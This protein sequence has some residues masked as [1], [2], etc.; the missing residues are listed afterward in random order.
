M[1]SILLAAGYATRLYPLTKDQ[2]KPLLKVADKAIADYIV[3][4]LMALEDM[5]CC[6]VVT[7]DKFYPHFEEWRSNHPFKERLEIVNDGTKNEDD[8]LGAIGDLHFVKNQKVIDDDLLIIAGDNLFDLSLKDVIS[9]SREKNTPCI[10]VKDLSHRKELVSKYGVVSL[11]EHNRVTD[12]EEKPPR[13]KS[14][15]I[16]VGIYYFPKKDLTYLEKYVTDGQK[17]DAPGFF[18]QW[19]HRETPVHAFGFREEWYDI[20][21]LNSLRDADELYRQRL[22][23]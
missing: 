9:F 16:A 8:R 10:C 14:T 5:D 4:E 12:F 21:D 13:P 6:Y 22:D 18:I 2:P 23:G 11:D 19:L 3:E 17:L 7:N 1:K 15:Y 20:G